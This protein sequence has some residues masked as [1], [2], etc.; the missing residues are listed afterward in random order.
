MAEGTSANIF[1]SHDMPAHAPPLTM[2]RVRAALMCHCAARHVEMLRQF[3]IQQNEMLRAM[4]SNTLN[5]SLLDEL[6]RLRAENERLRAR[7]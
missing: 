6:Q 1:L 5:Q 2:M 4:D 7:F 3:H